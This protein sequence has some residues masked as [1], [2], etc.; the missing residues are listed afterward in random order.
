MLVVPE[1]WKKKLENAGYAIYNHSAVQICHWT[2]KSILDQ[3]DCYKHRFY[4]ID[5]FG[6]MQITQSVLWCTNRC[7]YCWRPNEEFA[8]FYESLPEDQV[9]DPKTSLEALRKLRRDLLVGYKGNPEANKEKLMKTLETPTHVTFSLSGEPLLYPFVPESIKYIKENWKW[10]RSI[11]VVT[12]GLIPNALEKMKKKNVYPT[13]LYISFIAPTPELYKKISRTLLKDY[14]ERFLRSLEIASKLKVRR[15]ARITIIKGLNDDLKYLE[16]WKKLIDIYQPH[17][18]EVKAFMLLGYSRY[19]LSI[20]NMPSHE[21]IKE[22]S[23]KLENVLDGFVYWD[24]HV[25]SRVV[26]LKNIKDGFNIDPRINHVEP[27]V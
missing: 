6:C 5:T 9:D 14:W 12:N 1:E 21:Y 25:P 27:N 2:R 4:G 19:R 11:F 24:E 23:K 17:F 3:G 13:Q 16:E 7:I 22:W 15:V 10:V 8:E 20:E 26:L 18:V